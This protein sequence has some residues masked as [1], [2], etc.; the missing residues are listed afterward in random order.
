LF[1]GG[2]TSERQSFWFTQGPPVGTPH[3]LSAAKHVPER[4]CVLIGGGPHVAPFLR[5]H[6]LSA[7]SQTPDWQTRV[8]FAAVH[9][10]LIGAVAGSG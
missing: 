7:V 5:P 3:L 9:V 8:P 1:D 10:A 2:Q 4:H 6:R